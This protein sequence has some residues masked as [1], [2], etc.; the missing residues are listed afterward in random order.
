MRT[1][2][3][4]RSSNMQ[5]K[6]FHTYENFFSRNI[7]TTIKDAFNPHELHIE[8]KSVPQTRPINSVHVVSLVPK[9]Y[10]CFSY[11]SFSIL[12]FTYLLIYICYSLMYTWYIVYAYNHL[13]HSIALSTP[14][15]CC[16]VDVDVVWALLMWEFHFN[17]W[18][19]H[20]LSVICCYFSWNI[21]CHENVVFW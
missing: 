13:L 9:K 10:I 20:G 2:L 16:S 18:F 1:C 8:P 3:R 14:T 21:I 19:L 12:L 11:L 7:Y 15:S 17:V 5:I 6:K 4:V